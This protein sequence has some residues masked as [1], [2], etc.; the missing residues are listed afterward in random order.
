MTG[1]ES[2]SAAERLLADA[3]AYDGEGNPQTAAAR[4]SE[5]FTRA[6]LALTASHAAANHP[7]SVAWD[8]AINPQEQ[9]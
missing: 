5:A 4:R 1:P 2:Y 8:Q 3:D 7:D 9:T 6:V